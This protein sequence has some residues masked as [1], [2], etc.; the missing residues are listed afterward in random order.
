MYGG[1]ALVAGAVELSNQI[2]VVC[3]LAMLADPRP[4]RLQAHVLDTMPRSLTDY[5]EAAQRSLL[6]A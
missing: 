2:E 5:Y 1:Q 4:N 6:V 3:G